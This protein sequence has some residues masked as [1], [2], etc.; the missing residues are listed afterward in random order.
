MPLIQIYLG[1]HLS[2]QN[3]RDISQAVHQSLVDIFHIPSDDF[4]QVIHSMKA[5]DILYPDSYLD[6]PHTHNMLYIRITCRGGRTVEMKEAL[7]EKIASRIAAATP[8]SA[9]DV[10][11]IL[12]E[13][14]SADWSLGGGKAQMVV[15]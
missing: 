15:K 1:D 12:L 10:V 7:Y 14:E 6:V 4:F 5:G 3:K 8:V 13:N 2:Q 11:I 9:N